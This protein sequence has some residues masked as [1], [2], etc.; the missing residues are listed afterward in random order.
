MKSVEVFADSLIIVVAPQNLGAETSLL[1]TIRMCKRRLSA[2]ANNSLIAR[3][4]W[5]VGCNSGR[6][7]TTVMYWLR[8]RG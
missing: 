4:G 6:I 3:I 7:L 2:G 8:M 1:A 5:R